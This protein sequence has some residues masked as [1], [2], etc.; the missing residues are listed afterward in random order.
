MPITFRITT[1]NSRG[2]I[3]EN[4]I[5]IKHL[6]SKYPIK[7]I[8]IIKKW[9]GKSTTDNNIIEH[10][11]TYTNTSAPPFSGS[12]NIFRTF[13]CTIQIP[14]GKNHKRKKYPA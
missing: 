5:F 2:F 12:E 6:K 13:G 8:R 4:L 14:I 10:N 3:N 9:Q 7:N 1:N 11:L